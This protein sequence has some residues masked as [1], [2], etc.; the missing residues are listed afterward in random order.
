MPTFHDLQ[1]GSDLWLQFRRDKISASQIG[2]ILGLSPWQTPYQLWSEKIG[3]TEPEEATAAMKR[4]SL[5][6]ADA[7]REYCLMRGI[8]M[9]SAVV[10]HSDF[11]DFMAS[12]DGISY[13]S[14][15][16]V[17]IKC[18][19]MKGHEE[20]KNGDVKPLYIAQMNWQMFCTGLSTCDYFSYDGE[21]GY[22]IEVGRDEVLISKMFTAA[23]EFLNYCRSLSPPPFTDLDYEDKSDDDYWN[24]LCDMYERHN[25]QEK[26]AILEKDKVKKKMIEYA[27]G[28]NVK[29]ANSKFT[30]YMMEGKINYEVIPELKDVNLDSYR[31]PSIQCYRITTQK[32]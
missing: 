22:I 6:E 13:D 12:L 23:N 1:Q 18:P 9:K 21:N 3:L 31:K 28:R 20:S 17:E 11:P 25:Q 30:G 4:G 14:Q 24:R 10:T 27:N 29:G 8:E 5:M 26:C 16:I 32:D 7:L 2:V 15:H 19:G